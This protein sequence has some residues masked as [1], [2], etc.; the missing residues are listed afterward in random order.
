MAMQSRPAGGAD[1][2]FIP[3]TEDT[4]AQL[5][6]IPGVE[7]VI[8]RDFLNGGSLMSYN[9]LESYPSLIGVGTSDLSQLGTAS[10]QRL[11]GIGE[12][13]RGGRGDGRQ[14]FLRSPLAPRSADP[15]ASGSDGAIG[16]AD[17]DQDICRRAAKHANLSRSR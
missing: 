16:K 14:Q 7:A 11:V 15:T 5:A 3:I 4:L 8:P 13:R 2:N 1:P 10:P 12:G 6:A 17:P 9:R